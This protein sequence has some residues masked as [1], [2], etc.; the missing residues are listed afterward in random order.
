MPDRPRVAITPATKV[1]DLLASWPELEEVLI[2]QAPAFRRLKNPVLRR[3][4]ARVATLEQAAGVGGVPV[5]QLVAALRRAAGLEGDGAG[6][7]SARDSAEPEAAPDWLDPARVIEALDA[8]ALLDAGEVP[9]TRVGARARQLG[10]GQLLRIDS[11]FRPAPLLEALRKQGYRCFARE[12]APGRFETFVASPGHAEPGPLHR[13]FAS[14]HRRLAELLRRATAGE[15]PIDLGPYGAFRAGL[16]RHIGMEEKVLL[17]AAREAR[18]GEPLPI[19][20]RLRVDHGAIAAML[21]P[22]PT[23]ALVAKILSVLGPHNGREEEPDG[24]YDA[25][26]QALGQAAAT[27]LV[28]ELREF[29]EPPLKPYN[30]A[31]AVMSHIAVNLELARRQWLE[32]GE[33]ER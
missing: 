23:R 25:C 24:V 30:D 26:D 31:P 21:V 6:E 3:T 5:R 27:R 1:A 29:P 12:S 10:P 33:G 14:D 17:V 4:V 22:T 28:E 32:S 11:G 2:A 19:A 8:E 18:G 13:F 15:G 20:E 9:L 7:A 16:L